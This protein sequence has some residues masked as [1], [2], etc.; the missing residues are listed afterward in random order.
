MPVERVCKGLISFGYV[1][2]FE[3]REEGETLGS[4]WIFLGGGPADMT[5]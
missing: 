1:F 5:S 3:L 4:L 2:G